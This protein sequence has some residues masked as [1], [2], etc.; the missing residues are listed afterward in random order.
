MTKDCGSCKYFAQGKNCSF[1]SNP[2]Q[3]NESKKQYL[4]YN[5]KCDLFEEG[6]HR[7]RIDFMKTFGD[8]ETKLITKEL[9]FTKTIYPK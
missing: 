2:K 8:E 1:C 7:T 3:M 6:I 4:Y 9:E 5:F